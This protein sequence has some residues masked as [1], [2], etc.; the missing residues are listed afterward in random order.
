MQLRLHALQQVLVRK[1]AKHVVHRRP[2]EG[3]HVALAVTVA[4]DGRDHRVNELVV[5]HKVGTFTLDQQE[6]LQCAGEKVARAR[7][8]Q[9]VK[10][11]AENIARVAKLLRR[12][13]LKGIKH[14]LLV[15]QR[16]FLVHRKLRVKVRRQ[17]VAHLDHNA[18]QAAGAHLLAQL[19]PHGDLLD[20]IA[21]H[22]SIDQEHVVH[23]I[24]GQPS[25]GHAR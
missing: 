4:H 11:E 21:V 14:L 2:H 3:G 8:L 1:A 25:V 5:V 9:P 22:Q 19:Q 16:A 24:F 20:N 12:V 10:D 15:L 23:D 13:A 17:Q 18:W 7:V 6:I